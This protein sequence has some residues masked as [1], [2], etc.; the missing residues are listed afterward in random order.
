L[1]GPVEPKRS[2]SFPLRVR[3][4]LISL[5]SLVVTTACSRLRLRG[6]EGSDVL[7]YTVVSPTDTPTPFVICYITR[8]VELPPDTPTPVC[9]TPTP[10][11]SASHTPTPTLTPTPL[12]YTPTPSPTAISADTPPL[13]T[14]AKAPPVMCYVPREDVEP[15]AP[16]P[17]DVTLPTPTPS[18]A[19]HLLLEELLARGRFPNDVANELEG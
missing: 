10:S 2:L 4:A 12:C 18:E 19:R 13:L 6:I 3:I 7:C 9:Y 15:A 14:P 8:K 16:G 5:L 11:L 17:V 1:S